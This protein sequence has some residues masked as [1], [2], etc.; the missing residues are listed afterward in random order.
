MFR[1]EITRFTQSNFSRR[2]FLRLGAIRKQL[3][4][5]GKVSIRL[6]SARHTR[7]RVI[8][9]DSH[10]PS[11]SH[12]PLCVSGAT[13]EKSCSRSIS[14]VVCVKKAEGREFLSA[15]TSARGQSYLLH[16]RQM[17]IL[18]SRRLSLE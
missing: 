11:S 6:L 9:S 8:K 7:G 14:S 10:F 5:Q 15:D 18:S 17:R 12:T 1:A 3:G 16:V 4:F 2:N 13:A